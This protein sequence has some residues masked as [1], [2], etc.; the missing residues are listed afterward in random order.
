MLRCTPNHACSPISL[1]FDVDFSM[2]LTFRM[3]TRLFLW[4]KVNL[5]YEI[6]RASC[7]PAALSV[8]LIQLII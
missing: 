4:N 7:V 5:I 1:A 2:K 3:T 8:A 6:I